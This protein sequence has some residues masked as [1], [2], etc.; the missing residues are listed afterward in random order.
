[1]GLKN[2]THEKNNIKPNS[3]QYNK[4]QLRMWYKLWK[5]GLISSEEVPT[6]FR[7][8]LIRYYG[9][10]DLWEIRNKNHDKG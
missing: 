9:V 5:A 6:K 7:G 10:P 1:M 2:A 4:R 3:F 8:L